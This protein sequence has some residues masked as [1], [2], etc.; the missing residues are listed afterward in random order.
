MLEAGFGGAGAEDLAEL[1]EA[2][3]FADVELDQ[4]QDRAAQGAS[5]RELVCAA[6]AGVW[7]ALTR[8]LVG[9]L[10]VSL[11]MWL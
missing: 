10:V 8:L 4:D 7:S 9:L 5:G 6:A 11:L 3:F 2:D 1:V